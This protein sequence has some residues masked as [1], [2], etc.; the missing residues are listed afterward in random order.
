MDMTWEEFKTIVD[1]TI[2]DFDISKYEFENYNEYNKRYTR[3]IC[4]DNPDPWKIRDRLENPNFYSEN[5]WLIYHNNYFTDEEWKT[6]IPYLNV[7]EAEKDFIKLQKQISTLLDNYRKKHSNY[8]SY[9]LA[10]LANNYYNPIFKN[11]WKI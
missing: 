3:S 10:H 7:N 8:A 2:N 5:L 11:N 4:L 6:L 9:F 1:K